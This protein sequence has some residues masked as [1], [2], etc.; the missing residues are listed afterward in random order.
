MKLSLSMIGMLCAMSAC[1]V[2]SEDDDV[3]RS[4]FDDEG[5]W[6]DSADAKTACVGQRVAVDVNAPI[7]TYYAPYPAS[8]GLEPRVDSPQTLALRAPG[9]RV[10]SL[11][12]PVVPCVGAVAELR[13]WIEGGG[14]VAHT[15]TIEELN[16][17]LE[18]GTALAR[19]TSILD[20][21]YAYVA[22]DELAVANT[23]WRNGGVRVAPFERL[24]TSLAATGLDRRI[25]F[26]VNSYNMVGTFRQYS[27]VLTAMRD[28]GRIVASEIYVTTKS[29]KAP[30]TSAPGRCLRSLACFESIADEM[31]AAVPGINYRTIT[32]LGVSD[33]Y[34]QGAADALCDAPGGGHGML[35]RQYAKLHQGA[36]TKLQPGVGAYTL[37]RIER[38]NHPAWGATDHVACKNRL[39]GWSFP[40]AQ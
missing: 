20:A 8:P 27:R 4:D 16:A 38:T 39:D 9:E 13:P 12:R 23:G 26:Y 15:M 19:I 33:E 17:H 10:I 11:R 22:I 40:R 25:I 5:V 24:L 21:G 29:I 3:D 6:S 35:Y 30:A 34:T 37:A 31:R 1:S 28:H 14:L 36:S 2:G 32:V 7:F 18:G